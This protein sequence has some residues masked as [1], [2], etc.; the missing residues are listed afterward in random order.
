MRGKKDFTRLGP[1][2][3]AQ[4]T[5]PPAKE[6]NSCAFTLIELPVVIVII[7]ILPWIAERFMRLG[8]LPGNTYTDSRQHSRFVICPVTE[9]D[10]K[11]NW[12]MGAPG[13]Q[14]FWYGR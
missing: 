12:A 5:R 14:A 1:F 2:D 6:R 10:Y 11:E 8:Y 3:A 4:G 7:A 13:E 9:K